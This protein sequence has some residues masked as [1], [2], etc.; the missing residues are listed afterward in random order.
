[1]QISWPHGSLFHALY[2]SAPGHSHDS[3]HAAMPQR[4]DEREVRRYVTWRYVPP[5]RSLG[6]RRCWYLLLSR[7][8][9]SPVPAQHWLPAATNHMNSICCLQWYTSILSNRSACSQ[10]TTTESNSTP[11]TMYQHESRSENPFRVCWT[12]GRVVLMREEKFQMCRCQST[13]YGFWHEVF[14]MNSIHCMCRTEGN[15]FALLHQCFKSF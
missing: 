5:I 15:T 2:P 4:A 1:M 14:G 10:C 13:R 8:P 12:F 7:T 6:T 3:M 9:P 11:L